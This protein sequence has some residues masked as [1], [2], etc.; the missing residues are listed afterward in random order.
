MTV[1]RK[2]Q[3]GLIVLAVS[4]LISAVL[5]HLSGK[6][7]PEVELFLG[8]VASLSSFLSVGFGFLQGRTNV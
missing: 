8:L 1:V 4:L 5:I 6:G 7:A 2:I 3:A